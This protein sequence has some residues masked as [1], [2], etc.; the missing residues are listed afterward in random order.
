MDWAATDAAT[1]SGSP[2]VDHL[3]DLGIT[4]LWLMPFYPTGRP[5]RRLRHHRLLRRGPATGHPRRPG[6][7]HPDGEGPRHAGDR[8]PG[9][10][11]HLDQAPVVPRGRAAPD[12]PFRDFYVWRDDPPPDTKKQVVFPDQ[13]SSIWTRSE[14]TGEWYLHLFYKE[15]PD[16]NVTNPRVRDELAKVMGFWLQL[17]PGRFPRRRR[18]LPA[19]HRGG[20]CA[21]GRPFPRPAR[22]P[23]GAAGAGGP[24]VR[25]RDPAG[26]GEPAVRAAAGVLRR[27]GRRR[28][29]HAVRL[30]HHAAA[31]PVPG[32]RRRRT[33]GRGADR[34]SAH[35]A[36]LAVGDV[37]PQPRRADPRQA[38]RLRTPGGLRRVRTRTGDAGLRA[39]AAP[40]AAADAGRR[41]AADP[42]GLQPAVLPARHPCALLRRGD[43]DGGG[44]GPRRP[45]G[46]PH[47]DA[48]DLRPQRRVLR[49]PRPAG[50]GG[51]W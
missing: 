30:H 44:P 28:A 19:R 36:G 40:P 37:R 34:P 2:S 4:C 25:G 49:A 11:P 47:A 20:R 43:R 39:R 17:G 48:V 23:A 41:P 24:A 5:R 9:R 50:C 3:A 6:R 29:D 7:G 45:D 1:S 21:G 42:D 27:P 8:R 13:E 10:Q 35:V 26:R 46:G 31:L 16:L 12:N 14:P 32:P 15:Q 38:L 22:V 18:P 51:P 33:G